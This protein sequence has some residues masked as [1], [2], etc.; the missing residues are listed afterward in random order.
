MPTLPAGKANRRA[1]S[2]GFTLVE[3]L[4]VVTIIAILSLGVGLG[5]GG[6]F[7]RAPSGP[8]L[9]IAAVTEA[10]DGAVL[11]RAARGLWPRADGWIVVRRDGDGAWQ[12]MGRAT[13]LRGLG[14]SVA[15]ASWLPG[16]I[17][18]DPGDTPPILFLPDGGGTGFAVSFDG[19]R[20]ASD[21]WGVPE[22]A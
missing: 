22:C 13:G 12:P 19:V 21:G 17:A 1:G 3:L 9:L 15:G 6:L 10:R 2:A 18:P 4:V 16:L 7:S 8:A 5:A 14:W 11:G 20:C